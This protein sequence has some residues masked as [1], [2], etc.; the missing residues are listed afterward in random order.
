MSIKRIAAVVSGMDEEYPYH[1]I[2]GINDVV[3]NND[4]NISYFAAYGN[5]IRSDK[6]DVGEL[7][8]YNLPDFSKFDGAILITNTFANPELRDSVIANVK[9]AHIPTV[10]F[11]CKDH[12]EFYDICIDNYSV[13]KLLVEHL[14]EEHGARTL[15]VVSGP[16]SNPEAMDRF[17]AF[18]DALRE[19]GIEPDERR[20]YYAGFKS[21]DGIKAIDAFVESGLPLPDAFVCANDSMAL[22]LMTKLQRMGYKVPE[23]VVVTGFDYT[24]NARNSSP[25]LTTVRRPLYNS[26]IEA[27][28]IIV[29]LMNGIERP[30]HT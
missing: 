29:D 17:N 23:D 25:A 8:I 26:G 14:I 24:F 10:I 5:I 9:S 3:K 18:K 28:S 21:Y 11:E 7:S 15:N 13:M 2:R 1:I 22:T 19:H 27:C 12:E 6:L 20:I 4:V 30:H 16:L